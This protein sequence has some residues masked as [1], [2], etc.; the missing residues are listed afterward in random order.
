[1][2]ESFRNALRVHI[3]NASLHEPRDRSPLWEAGATLLVM[4]LAGG[5]IVLIGFS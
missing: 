4:M 5:L 3:Q 2:S 1:M